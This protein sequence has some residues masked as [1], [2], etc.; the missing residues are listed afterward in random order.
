MKGGSMAGSSPVVRYAVGNALVVEVHGEVDL[1]AAGDLRVQ[2]AEAI[3]LAPPLLVIDLQHTTFLDSTALG[4]LVGT[5][6][7]AEGHG[8]RVVLAGAH[9]VVARVLNITGLASALHH[10][11]DVAA[12]IEANAP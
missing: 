12:A 2:L 4:V 7:R 10:Y 8:T 1:A 3:E 6:S 11:L 5:H 9:G